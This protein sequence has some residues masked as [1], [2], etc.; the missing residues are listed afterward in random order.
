[1]FNSWRKEVAPAVA[2]EELSPGLAGV[3][4]CEA[5]AAAR[6]PDDLAAEGMKLG[7]GEAELVTPMLMIAFWMAEF[8]L[9]IEAC[10]AGSRPADALG[11]PTQSSGRGKRNTVES[12]KSK[13][14]RSKGR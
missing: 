12:R 6:F 14:C 2:C 9:R 5:P 4:S 8:T 3:G 11:A 1:L 13:F 7:E 10:C